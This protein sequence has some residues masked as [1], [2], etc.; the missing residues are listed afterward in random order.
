VIDADQGD[1]VWRAADLG[2]QQRIRI[3][4]RV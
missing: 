3:P 1:V 2:T 4:K